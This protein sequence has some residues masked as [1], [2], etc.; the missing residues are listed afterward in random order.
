MRLAEQTQPTDV[1]LDSGCTISLIDS[2]FLHQNLPSIDIVAHQRPMRVRGVGS[3]S[4]L[5]KFAVVPL[6]LSGVLADARKASA[7]ITREFH[8]IDNLNAK[9]LIG[10]DIAGPEHFKVDYGEC[11]LTIGACQNLKVPIRVVPRGKRVDTVTMAKEKVTI[12]PREHADVSIV[13]RTKLPTDRDLLFEPNCNIGL[14][15]IG[16]L[17]THLVDHITNTV[18]ISNGTD[19]KVTIQRKARLGR[20]V[21][22]DEGVCSP[23]SPENYHLARVSPTGCNLHVSA[24]CSQLLQARRRVDAVS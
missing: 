17:H 19:K 11:T 12:P 13:T 24:I 14:G 15:S 3:T 22:F 20:I 8:V 21:D 4:S 7:L 18:R 16:G 6:Y 9:A 23:T 5:G 2:E 10:S 1:C